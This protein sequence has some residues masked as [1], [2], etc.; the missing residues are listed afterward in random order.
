[1]ADAAFSF[2]NLYESEEIVVKKDGVMRYLS[3]YMFQQSVER[4]KHQHNVLITTSMA[5][6]IRRKNPAVG[7][8]RSREEMVAAMNNA[9]RDYLD[10]QDMYPAM[11]N[12]RV[13]RDYYAMEQEFVKMTGWS[14]EKPAEVMI[15]VSPYDP[16]FS[17]RSAFRQN[18]ADLLYISDKELTECCD[19]SLV[20]ATDKTVG[21]KMHL[22]S[23]GEGGKFTQAK[24][25]ISKGETADMMLTSTDDYSGLARLSQYMTEADYRKVRRHVN[26]IGMRGDTLT[27]PNAFMTDEAVDRAEAILKYL[28]QNGIAY[29]VTPDRMPGQIQAEIEGTKISVRLTDRREHERYV[30]R[31]YDNGVSMTYS[32]TQKQPGT[33]K[34]IQYTPTTEECVDLVRFAMGEK[35][36]TDVPDVYRNQSGR[37]GTPVFQSYH[38]GDNFSYAVRTANT[39]KRTGQ[40]DVVR[41]YANGESRSASTKYF[42]KES[43]E[44]YLRN[45]VESA[46]ENFSKEIDVNRLI[47]ESRRHKDEPDYTPQ[48]SVDSSIAAIQHQ[49]W[50]VLTGRQETLLR[51][52]RTVD[53]YNE[54]LENG[55]VEFNQMNAMILD[56]MR[57]EGTPEEI[58]RQHAEANVDHMIGHYEKTSPVVY[59]PFMY[60][61]P[62]RFDPVNVASY[63]TSEY[64]RYRN[65][66]DL[67]A[68]M[69]MVGISPSEL[70][71]SDFY[72]KTVQD[73]MVKFDPETAR[74]MAESDNPF[75]QSMFDEIA[76]SIRRNGC[77][78]EDND[79][80]MD[81]NGIVHY[82]AKRRGK[83]SP[84]TANALNTVQGEIGQIFVPGEYGA[85]TT[86]F[87]GSDNYMFV[88]GYEAYIVPQQLGEDKSVEERT[89]LKGYEQI[90]RQQ[91]RYQLH[92][93]LMSDVG[94]MPEMVSGNLTAPMY[95]TTTSVNGVYRRL[96]DE[97]HPIDFMERSQEEGLPESWRKAILETEGRRVRYGNDIK[98]GST[99]NADYQAH[100]R[101]QFE[102][103]DVN[104][105]SLENDN[106]GDAY[107]LTGR[108][109]MSIMTAE[110]DGYFDPIATATSTNQGITRYLVESA[111][112][113]PDGSI[114]R[115]DL[116]DRCPLMKHSDM[117]YS[118]F[119]P[120][121][122]QQMTFSNGMRASAITK[123]VNVAQMTFGGWTFDDPVV[124]SK[125]FAEEYQIRATDGQMRNLVVGDKVS[126]LHGNKGVISLV[127]DP[128]MDPKEAAEQG[129]S[130]PVAWFKANPDLDVVMAPFPAVSRYNGGSA[131][132]LME[133]SKDLV[134]PDGTVHEGCM[135]EMKFIVTH[136]AVDA[137]T[138]VYDDDDVQA[139]KGRK[140]S[141]QLAWALNSKDCPHIMQECYGHNSSATS[142]LR[143]MLITT[144]LDMGPT[145]TLRVGYA[146]HTPEDERKVFEMPDLAYK[147][148]KLDVPRMRKEFAS[149]IEQSG[150][151]LEMPFPLQFPTKE[152]TPRMNSDKTDVEYKA[153]EWERKG[154]FRKDGTW[155]NPTTVRRHDDANTSRTN[156]AAPTYGLPIM[157]SYLRSGQEFE[158]GTSTVHDYTNQYLSI[159]ESA[160]KYRDAEKQGNLEEMEKQKA[161]AQAVYDRITDDLIARKF[162]GKH[163]V[164]RDNIMGSRMPH[165]ATAVWTADPRLDIDQVA[166]GPAMMESIGVKD[167]DHV[168]IWRDPMLRDA[169]CRYLRVK[170]DDRLTGVAINPVMDK[171]FDGDFDGDSVAV[172]ALKSP[173]AQREAMAKFSVG[174]NLLDYGVRKDDG[175]HPLSMQDSLDMKVSQHYDPKLKERFA[176]ITAEVNKFEADF[177]NG[178]IAESD[179]VAKRRG[180]VKALNDYYHDGLSHQYGQ[181]MGCFSDAKSHLKAIV[182]DCVETGAK[183]SAKKVNDYMR[184]FGVAGFATDIDHVEDKG[185]PLV[186]RHDSE[187]V[188][189][190]CAVKSFGTGVAGMFSIRAISALRSECP[191]AALELTYPVT[192]CTLQ[193]KHDPVDARHRYELL[194]GSARDLWR[195]RLLEPDAS[196]VWRPVKGSDGKPMQATPEQWERQFCLMHT[197]KYGKETMSDV[198]MLG[199]D[200]NPANV[201]E[202]AAALTGP[203]G[204]IMDIETTARENK[205]TTMDKMAYGGNFQTLVQAAKEGKNVF[206][207]K[208]NQGFA[209]TPVR[210]N[211]EAVEAGTTIKAI[212]KSDTGLGATRT[213]KTPQTAVAVSA[214]NAPHRVVGRKT[215]SSDLEDIAQQ[216]AA[217][218][219][220]KPNGDLGDQ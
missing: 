198:Q 24:Y 58:V 134:A 209:P 82:T 211:M 90:M 127:V 112:V 51:P 47:R 12:G 62:S 94:S 128:D 110:G 171:C 136:M 65:N 66:D 69:K 104:I 91:I 133:H 46:R 3:E 89:R 27:N 35:I 182:H 17:G 140:A 11:D 43:A 20:N 125:K 155:V 86:K 13:D 135:G 45:A 120:F 54:A 213:L 159:Y 179:L 23:K 59:N 170:Q 153:A 63:M 157:S 67:V 107:H 122:R 49:Y 32:T 210:K 142:G 31:V 169:G 167:D 129:L 212:T 215:I 206:E 19:G 93:D 101:Q 197:G 130:E 217:L 68:A 123:P 1:M 115:G 218:D 126:D 29:S 85:I 44:S 200:I 75:V 195:G 60:E 163:N 79:V 55:D 168:M 186:D 177:N 214:K 81:D 191:K 39:N 102:D 201:K 199:V 161:S 48:Y 80:L 53:E 77:E 166:M 22:Y 207:G 106:F 196:G 181:A 72:N 165:S 202:V 219:V 180:A 111:K 74:P 183:G 156:N 105:A 92:N 25:R 121:D 117:R 109:N 57:Y 71:G 151:V 148:G 15:P 188:Q 78:L 164:F 61:N 174:A 26:Q 2:V 138:H 50:E 88:P 118:G 204:K 150:G 216:A 10:G 87:A 84:N 144:G 132:E 97:R 175:L 76:T 16:R 189:Y 137:K 96:Y 114:E 37:Y 33:N 34:P 9:F 21:Q 108:R 41:I 98:E 83:A 116:D 14:G 147:N 185:A 152:Q 95:G 184:Y 146:P 158:D 205:A 40:T 220:Q 141:A 131:R 173:E 103:D 56:A 36:D 5:R 18:G 30:G 172:V 8:A 42:T 193:S 162:T 176:G 124:V 99:I 6:D 208:F 154:Y 52:G 28:Q 194:M 149:V 178:K 139:G 4:M 203:D 119:N 143:E 160:C 100:N 73:R 192:Q 145:G 38:S 7:T 113:N 190:A 64:G 70:K 187:G